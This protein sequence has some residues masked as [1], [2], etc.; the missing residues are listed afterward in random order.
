[1]RIL[2]IGDEPAVVSVITRGLKEAN[3]EVSVAPDDAVGMELATI[4]GLG[5]II[6]DA[7]LPATNSI[8]LCKSMR[9]KGVATPILMLTSSGARENIIAI[10]ESG[11][12]DYMIKPFKVMELIARIRSLSRRRKL[13]LGP[14]S[15]PLPEEPK[16]YNMIRLGDLALNLDIKEAMRK[17]RVIRLTDTEYRLLDYLIRNPN[18][19]LSR[20]EILENVWGADNADT[21]VVDAY[22]SYLRKKLTY[23]TD[24]EMIHTV[25]GQGYML[26]ET[27]YDAHL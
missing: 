18:R 10:M 2:L 3:Y 9:E 16:N 7:M 11:A 26:S 17:N 12:D 19:V 24:T 23:Y 20:V 14:V 5:M 15:R 21:K 6:V 13:G 8:A 22:I 25:M 27:K 1:M 4:A